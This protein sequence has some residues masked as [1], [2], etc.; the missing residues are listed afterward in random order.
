MPLI[1]AVYLQ[2]L[3]AVNLFHSAVYTRQTFD[4]IRAAFPDTILVWVDILPRFCWRA[5][6]NEYKTIN[7]KRRRVNQLGHQAVRK[8]GG[9]VLHLD[10]DLTSG[11]FREDGVHLSDVGLDMYIDNLRELLLTIF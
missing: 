7:R 11:L 4:Y 6:K 8:A 2:G 1:T 3:N 10:I 9:H 5:P